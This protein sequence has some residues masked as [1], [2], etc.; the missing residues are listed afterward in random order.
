MTSD[1]SG[2]VKMR[3]LPEIGIPERPETR[4]IVALSRAD[5]SGRVPSP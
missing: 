5:H 2:Y 4:E 3:A 1:V